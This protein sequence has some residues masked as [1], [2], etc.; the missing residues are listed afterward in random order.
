HFL[1]GLASLFVPVT[2]RRRTPPTLPTSVLQDHNPHPPPTVGQFAYNSW[3][4]GAV[5]FPGLGESYI[6]PVFGETVRRLSTTVPGAG[7]GGTRVYEKNGWWNADASYFMYSSPP[8][9]DP[10]IL[11]AVTGATVISFPT[12]PLGSNIDD[13][14][15][16]PVDCD[17]Y[18]FWS[19]A[20]LKN[21]RIS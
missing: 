18:W 21:F 9:D 13:T 2:R 20:D 1:A 16:D 12:M 6:D 7:G 5:G 10:Y 17:L 4:P 11:N 8:F 14:S 3:K 15:F 19:G